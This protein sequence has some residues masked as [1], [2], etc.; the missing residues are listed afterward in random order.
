MPQSL[1]DLL[2]HII[3]STKDR[4]PLIV[5]DMRPG[6]HSYLA[7]VARNSE[8]ECFCVGGVGWVD[9]P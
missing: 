1:A 2:V 5:D 4:A 3:F 7:T 9:H 8:C 6:L